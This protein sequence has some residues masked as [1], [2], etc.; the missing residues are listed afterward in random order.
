MPLFR[1]FF[2]TNLQVNF[3]IVSAAKI[4]IESFLVIL[5]E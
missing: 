1:C 3:V 5:D 4:V 2:D